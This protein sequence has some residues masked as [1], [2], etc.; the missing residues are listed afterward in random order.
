MES[1]VWKAKR[2]PVL[3]VREKS[4]SYPNRALETDTVLSGA[5]VTLDES[6]AVSEEAALWVYERKSDLALFRR[7]PPF[8]SSFQSE[9]HFAI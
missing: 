7:E 3:F 1:L 6:A 8:F 5:Q 9:G 2:R 4:R